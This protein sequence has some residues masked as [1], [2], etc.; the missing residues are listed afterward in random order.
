[1]P[2][3]LYILSP[4]APD[5]IIPV[6]WKVTLNFDCPVTLIRSSICDRG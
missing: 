2:L 3:S 1:M 4:P 6:M 5:S